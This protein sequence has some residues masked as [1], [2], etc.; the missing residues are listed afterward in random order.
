MRSH[1]GF[2]N[3]YPFPG[4]KPYSVLCDLDMQAFQLVEKLFA[5]LDSPLVGK[6]NLYKSLHLYF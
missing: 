2:S 4:V 1:C 6:R 3:F 5:F